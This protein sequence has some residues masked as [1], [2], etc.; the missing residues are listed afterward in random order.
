M[1]RVMLSWRAYIFQCYKWLTS[2]WRQSLVRGII[3]YMLYWTSIRDERKLCPWICRNLRKFSMVKKESRAGM[4]IWT[5]NKCITIRDNYQFE[6]TEKD[7]WQWKI[8]YPK[9]KVA[10]YTPTIIPV[11][12]AE[13]AVY[14]TR[15]R[16]NTCKYNNS[17]TRNTRDASLRVHQGRPAP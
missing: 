9:Q 4:I 11:I 3:A 14:K 5:E 2:M 10:H 7:E 1:Q 15:L 6:G 17:A 13:T 16:P 8:P 12:T